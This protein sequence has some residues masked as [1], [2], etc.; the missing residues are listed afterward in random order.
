MSKSYLNDTFLIII[1]F[2]VLISFIIIII[3]HFTGTEDLSDAIRVNYSTVEK[4]VDDNGNPIN[5]LTNIYSIEGVRS[6]TSSVG[7][8]EGYSAGITVNG[9]SGGSG[10]VWPVTPNDYLVFG[11][12]TNNSLI[13]NDF[14]NRQFNP[15][16][17]GY[18][19]ILTYDDLKR[20]MSS[21]SNTTTIN[22]TILI[23]D[24]TGKMITGYCTY[25]G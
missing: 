3:G 21:N 11:T 23:S 7:F 1:S 5:Y 17:A 25:N 20:N 16:S 9:T 19:T 8:S 13:T 14:S 18:W 22:V 12:S 10:G 2:L 15:G 24:K 6:N 4:V